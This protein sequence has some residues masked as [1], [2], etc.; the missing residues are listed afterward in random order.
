MRAICHSD[1][2]RARLPRGVGPQLTQ[3]GR[4]VIQQGSQQALLVVE[5]G[6]KRP[7]RQTRLSA[8][9]VHAEI[10]VAA[11]GQTSPLGIDQRSLALGLGLTGKFL[12][13]T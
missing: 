7:L 3:P 13:V 6:V 5:V 10:A 11:T 1:T 4:V 9:V 12:N 8:Y 2:C